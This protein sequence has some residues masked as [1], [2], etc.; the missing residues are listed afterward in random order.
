MQG[1][2]YSKEEVEWWKSDAPKDCKVGVA[3]FREKFGRE[4]THVVYSNRRRYY[5]GG[6]IGSRSERLSHRGDVAQSDKAFEE[7]FVEV[8]FQLKNVFS[9]Y[10]EEI[11]RLK[12]KVNE[13]VPLLNT[14]SKVKFD[15]ESI[16]GD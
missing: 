5:Q 13:V 10:E 8:L 12:K 4:L 15:I 9:Q 14:L 7:K 3:Q 1:K 2:R 6:Q 11:K 16:N